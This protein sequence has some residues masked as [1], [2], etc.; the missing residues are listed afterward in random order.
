MLQVYRLYSTL[1][2]TFSFKE[3]EN[4]NK[5]KKDNFIFNPL[6]YTPSLMKGPKDKDNNNNSII[7]KRL[8][9]IERLL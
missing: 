5:E 3:K 2:T 8:D 4:S 7:R 9:R 6:N 1:R